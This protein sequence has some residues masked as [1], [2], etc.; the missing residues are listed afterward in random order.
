MIGGK[1]SVSPEV[2]SYEKVIG[3]VPKTISFS[4][5]EIDSLKGKKFLITGAGGS[6]GSRITL[7]ISQLP[8]IEFLATDRD[9]TALHSLSLELSSR[10]L[11]D[12]PTLELLDIKDFE[13]IGL[14]FSK[15]KPDVVIH[16]AALKHLSALEKQPREA[17][18][19]NILG[20]LN[21]VEHAF[22][23]EIPY[24]INISTD[25]A[26]D[27]KSVLG[28]SKFLTELLVSD[29]RNNKGMKNWTSCRF[30][31]VFNS[32]G[33]VIE[34]FISQISKNEPIT[35]T[36]ENVS[37][38]FMHRDEA[39]FLTL[40][41]MLLNAGNVHIFDMGEP[42]LMRNIIQK[43]IKEYGSTS[44]IV[45]TGL[46]QGEKLN[47]EL[48]S[49]GELVDLLHG[50]DISVTSTEMSVQEKNLVTNVIE[51]DSLKIMNFL[52]INL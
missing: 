31:N 11:F 30:G 39:A 36:D 26:A 42:I 20:T 29:Y 9:E 14:A 46:R 12:T 15:F 52:S 51:R 25:K 50:E 47:E 40:K 32:R 28:K 23:A 5:A 34:T 45:I 48:F 8:G 35:L 27:P 37:R 24:F 38:F 13:G 21:L 22:H 6:I 10:A 33:S 1:L 41:S 43:L 44:P 4:N 7:L 18:H 49:K 16:A 2:I 3:R 19:T 17:L